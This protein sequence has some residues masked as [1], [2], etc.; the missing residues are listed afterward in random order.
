MQ[1]PTRQPCKWTSV[2]DQKL[3]EE[4]E[5]QCEFLAF[6]LSQPNNHSALTTVLW[7]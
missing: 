1:A 5:A 6:Q 4:V 7:G 3:R 2:E